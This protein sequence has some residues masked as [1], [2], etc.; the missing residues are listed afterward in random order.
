MCSQTSRITCFI[1]LG[2]EN[3]L[4]QGDPRL[5]I[6]AESDSSGVSKILDRHALKRLACCRL[7]PL[8]TKAKPTNLP[9]RMSL[10]LQRC[11]V[12]RVRQPPRICN[13]V[14]TVLKLQLGK[15]FVAPLPP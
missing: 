5:G 4:G 1:T 6:F 3:N 9:L 8:R 15:I 7:F 12:P 13:P 10:N 14:V 2:T 11:A